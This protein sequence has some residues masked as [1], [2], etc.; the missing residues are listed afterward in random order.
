[1][2]WIVSNLPLIGQY[3]AS[4]LALALPAILASLLLS[5]PLGWAAN[6][7][8]WT[9][10]TLVSATSLLYAIPS[11]P[12]FIMLPVLIGTGVRDPLNVIVALTLY[13]LA[14]MVRTASDA[15]GSVP[16]A[17]QQA[18]TAVGMTSWSK[19][20]RVQLPLASPVLLAGLRVVTVATISLVTVSSILG[21]PNLG[22]LF[23]DGF[24]RGITEEVLA[25]IFTTAL[26]ALIGDGALVLLGRTLLPWARRA[27]K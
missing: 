18:A 21:V 3:T 9:R 22:L 1:M 7:W 2:K 16:A 6:R 10:F 20:W 25:G 14:L 13:G 15:F 11:L 19:F 17:T 27:A 12:L 24:G 4:H 23:I 26:L 8:Q 5:I